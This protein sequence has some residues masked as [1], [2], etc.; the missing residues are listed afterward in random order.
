M[1]RRYA[2]DPQ[3]VRAGADWCINWKDIHV[4]MDTLKPPVVFMYIN[5]KSEC[6][7]GVNEKSWHVNVRDP[8]LPLYMRS[9][10]FGRRVL[11]ARAAKIVIPYHPLYEPDPG[12]FPKNPNIKD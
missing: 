6:C 1:V 8:L 4:R 9:G 11:Y 12:P 7:K 2:R 10:E 5:G 3:L